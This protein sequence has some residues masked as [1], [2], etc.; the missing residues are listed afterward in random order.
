MKNLITNHPLETLITRLDKYLSNIKIKIASPRIQKRRNLTA[1]KVALIQQLRSEDDVIL[2]MHKI[3]SKE[4]PL[5]LVIFF[6]IT[7][8]LIDIKLIMF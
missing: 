3:F 5:V 2:S 7:D 4:V 8:C 6:L 1:D